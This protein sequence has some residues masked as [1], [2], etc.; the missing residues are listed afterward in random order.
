MRQ[1]LFR[2]ARIVF[3]MNNPVLYGMLFTLFFVK[4]YFSLDPDFGWH[5]ASGNYMLAQG[6]P[7]S[8]IYSYTAPDFPWIHHE[9]LA[10]SINALLYRYGGYTALS[11]VSALL[12]TGAFW[13]V[14]RGTRLRA[15]VA[16]AA[17][18]VLPFAGVR[19]ITWTV[20]LFALLIAI[21]SQA[22]SRKYWMIPLIVLFWA[23]VHGSFV[24]GLVYIVWC[25]LANPSRRLLAV[26][27]LS[28]AAS[29][30]TPYGTA[31]YIE[32]LRT[33]TDHS[34]RGRIGEWRPFGLSIGAGIMAGIWGGLVWIQPGTW[35]K[36]L[37]HFELLLLVM[38]FFSVRHT[39]LFIIASLTFIVAAARQ[40][41]IPRTMWRTREVQWASIGIVCLIIFTAFLM[42]AS[43][44][45]GYTT[46]REREYPRQIATRLRQ[47][48]C[49]GNV[50]AHYDF[51]GYL[52]W[53]V[54][55]QK[56]YIDGRMPSWEDHG[57]KYMDNYLKIIDDDAFQRQ[58][59]AAQ[60]IRCVVW[61]GETAF[62][63]RLQAQGWQIVQREATNH[64]IVLEK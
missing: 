1:Y 21:L 23:N 38:A 19:A 25:Y 55:G 17:V 29:F 46:D 13:L 7:T 6:V 44:F 57:I 61:G 10:D 14:A 27:V 39:P 40:I 63:T 36:K 42:V 20:F 2:C 62:T 15:L 60:N 12:W 48:P 31:M 34:L 18:V 9:W 64:S 4:A 5:L 28:I 56:L 30:L 26:L 53:K 54:P 41:T 50:F 37:L 43:T 59:F 24:I 52:I 11:I 8:D 51:G 47:T 32:V 45:R 33:V 22:S 58:E 3:T 35:R 16:L 49:A